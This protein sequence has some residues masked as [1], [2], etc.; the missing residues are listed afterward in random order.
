MKETALT[1]SEIGANYVYGG[2]TSNNY[3]AYYWSDSCHY[4]SQTYGT[5]EYNSDKTTGCSGHNDYAGSKIKEVVDNY[6]TNYLD[7][8]DLKEVDGYKIR[9]ITVTELQ[10]NLYL[11]TILTNQYYSYYAIDTQNT[12]TWV[13]QNFGTNV[14]GYW[15]MSP[16]VDNSAKVWSVR[17]DAKVGTAPVHYV[18]PSL[19]YG[20]RPVINLLKSAVD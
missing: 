10:E 9:L 15:T 18:G 3:M 16:V 5:D 8:T 4:G 14:S 7:S 1:G 2:D 20:V 6:M 11:S 17:S 19:G 13:Y 12:P